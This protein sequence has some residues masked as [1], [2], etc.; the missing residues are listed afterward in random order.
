MPG[1]ILGRDSVASAASIT[2]S[3]AEGKDWR[4]GV[5]GGRVAATTAPAGGR[6]ATADAGC[7]AAR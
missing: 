5:A 3:E 1:L 4:E 7:A 2:D 6:G